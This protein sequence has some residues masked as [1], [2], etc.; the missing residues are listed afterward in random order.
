M[1]TATSVH[2]LFQAM[3]KAN[4]ERELRSRFMDAAGEIFGAQHWGIHLLGD[5]CRVL[6]VDVHGLPD[7]FI[8]RY[9][10]V[11]RA[12]D[13]IMQFVMEQHSPAH[14]QLVQA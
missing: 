12:I 2:S 8:S 10:Q 14:E 5:A 4:N 11:G 9:E 3:A 13:P 7:T 1:T 6:E